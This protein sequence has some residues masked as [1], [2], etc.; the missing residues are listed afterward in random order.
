[1]KALIALIV[2]VLAEVAIK[3]ISKIRPRHVEGY[4]N[5]TTEKR[6]KKK[7]RKDGWDV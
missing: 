7:A 5:G 1:M 4:S 2:K 6:L 3:V